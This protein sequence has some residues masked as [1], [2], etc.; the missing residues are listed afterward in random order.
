MVKVTVTRNG[1]KR[2]LV[3]NFLSIILHVYLQISNKETM[4][5][6]EYKK[7]NH[8]AHGIQTKKP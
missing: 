3:Q 7:R 4:M 6:M 2:L 1:K 8:D 5:S